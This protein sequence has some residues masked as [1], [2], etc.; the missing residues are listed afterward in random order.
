MIVPQGLA[1][2]EQ[3]FHH[4]KEPMHEMLKTLLI[5]LIFFSSICRA[6]DYTVSVGRGGNFFSPSNLSAEVGDEITFIFYSG[7]YLDH[8][9]FNDDTELLN[10]PIDLFH[11]LPTLGWRFQ[12]ILN[13]RLIFRR[14]VWTDACR[15]H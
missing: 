9:D 3:T 14:V 2:R 5:F 6:Y 12:S 8:T 10:H 15:I 1:S 11:P 4:S 7:V 13:T